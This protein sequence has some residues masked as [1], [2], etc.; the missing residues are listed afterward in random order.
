M[1]L[2][3]EFR[4]AKNIHALAQA[5]VSHLSGQAAELQ[6]TPSTEVKADGAVSLIAPA[7]LV[8]QVLS[9]EFPDV[10]ERRLRVL[11]V[12]HDQISFMDNGAWLSYAAGFGGFEQG[13]HIACMPFT[14]VQSNLYPTAV[15]LGLTELE[16][17]SHA[18]AQSQDW[19]LMLWIHPCLEYSEANEAVALAVAMQQAGVP[20]Y[21]AMYN[22][23]D[24]L[25]QSY[26]MSDRGLEFSWLDG[27]CTEKALSKSSVNRFGIATGD[28]GVDG[29]WG[30]VLTKLTAATSSI[31]P[32][33]WDAVKMAMALVRLDGEV[34]SDWRFAEAVGGV[35]FNTYSP[36]GLIGNMAVDR[37]S[38]LLLSSC[39]T[40][41]VLKVVG[42]VPQDL[43]DDLPVTPFGLVAW[44]ARV[45]ML[46]TN[47]ITRE[48]RKRKEAIELLQKAFSMGMVEAGI[49]LARIYEHIGTASSRL[50]ANGI[51]ARLGAGHFMSAYAL[52]HEALQSGHAGEALRYL[53]AASNAGYP[54]AMTDYGCLLLEAGE[55]ESATALLKAA[56]KRGDKEASFRLGE[57]MIQSGRY[58]EAIIELRKAWSAGHEEALALTEWLC[59]E[60]LKNGLGR[61]SL[62]K[63][64]QK[65]AK[66]FRNKRL[67]YQAK[68]DKAFA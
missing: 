48:D 19:D 50:N 45:K 62:V 52:A 27:T 64:E 55:V 9:L 57:V 28:I 32:G 25:I 59:A 36:V 30:A 60:M 40:T 21:A 15:D 20:V 13:V 5:W 66:S 16:Q 1:N 63:R 14:A 2:R 37:K 22:E 7:A 42:H 29:G 26:G 49:A 31:R 6:K 68:L 53:N 35:A 34:A 43:L 8:A 41:H 46:F 12:A 38:G 65:D 17:L 44:A 10:V 51:Y 3:S 4:K 47:S 11:M 24:A 54:P 18:E 33:D 67:R 39:S 23:L 56:G 58:H 61:A